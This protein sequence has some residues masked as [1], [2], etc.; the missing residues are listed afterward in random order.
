MKIMFLAP[1][2]EEW[3]LYSERIIVTLETERGN[4]NNG[5]MEPKRVAVNYHKR[6]SM[7]AQQWLE[8]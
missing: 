6:Q 5:I 4:Y 7:Q 8:W 3:H 2:W 1:R